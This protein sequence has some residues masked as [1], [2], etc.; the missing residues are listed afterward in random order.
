MRPWSWSAN[1]TEPGQTAWMCMH[2]YFVY[3]R[4]SPSKL[5]FMY[6]HVYILYSSVWI[7]HLQ[8]LVKNKWFS[9]GHCFSMSCRKIVKL[10]K[11][12]VFPL[13]LYIVYNMAKMWFEKTFAKLEYFQNTL[14]QPMLTLFKRSSILSNL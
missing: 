1:N 9:W 4:F 13:L 11:Q 8:W 2:N 3:P 12:I 10:V 6:S 14:Q 7:V 5:L